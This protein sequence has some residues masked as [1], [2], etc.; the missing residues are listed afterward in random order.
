MTVHYLHHYLIRWSTFLTQL[1][2]GLEIFNGFG[3]NFFFYKL[4]AP[5]MRFHYRAYRK[6]GLKKNIFGSTKERCT[7]KSWVFPGTSIDLTYS[8]NLLSRTR[9]RTPA[10]P[11]VVARLHHELACP[12]A[13]RKKN[14]LEKY[15]VFERLCLSYDDAWTRLIADDDPRRCCIVRIFSLFYYTRLVERLPRVAYSL[16]LVCTFMILVAP[17]GEKNHHLIFHQVKELFFLLLLH[18]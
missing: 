4:S 7:E 15:T 16:R 1:K 2:W 9:P 17:R 6:Y 5:S 12:T 14:Y 3:K 11:D 10:G 18:Q 8:S 13:G